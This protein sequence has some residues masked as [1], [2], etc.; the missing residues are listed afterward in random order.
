MN[1]ANQTELGKMQ[2]FNPT[3]ANLKAFCIMMVVLGHCGCSIPY[4]MQF[5]GMFRMPLFF[6]VSGYCFKATSLDNP[7]RYLGRRI[8]GV[9]W[10]CVKWGLFFMLLHNV[11]IKV[12]FYDAS[13]PVYGIRDFILHAYNIIVHMVDLEQLIGAYWFLAALFAGSFISWVL[14][15][16]VRQLEYSAAILMNALE[17]HIPLGNP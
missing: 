15:K 12:G 14:M 10:P 17:H 7:K 3:I 9:Y 4:A 8:Q 2:S 1:D 5:M 11:F 13:T 16:F 6:F